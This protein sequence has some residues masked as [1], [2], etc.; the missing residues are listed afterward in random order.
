MR[1][2][3][4]LGSLLIHFLLRTLANNL[5]APHTFVIGYN[6]CSLYGMIK[7]EYLLRSTNDGIGHSFH[8]DGFVSGALI[9]VVVRCAGGVTKYVKRP[10]RQSG[11][12]R[13][14]RG[15]GDN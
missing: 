15:R 3:I 4:S 11:V 9:Y 12:G 6:F 8:I 5:Q 1:L 2:T 10:G 13:R 7:G 14:L